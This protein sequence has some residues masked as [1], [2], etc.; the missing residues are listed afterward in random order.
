MTGPA[1]RTPLDPDN[2]RIFLGLMGLTL[3][4]MLFRPQP[5]RH[6]EEEPPLDRQTLV[7]IGACVALLLVF[8]PP[9]T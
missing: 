7:K 8:L 5:T 1:S 6:S 4:Y 9:E 2:L 3:I